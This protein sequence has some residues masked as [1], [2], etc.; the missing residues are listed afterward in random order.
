MKHLA[1]AAVLA[2]A[3]PASAQQETYSIDPAHTVPLFEVKHFGMSTQ[4]GFFNKASGKITVDRAAKTGNAD[5]AIDVGSVS[6]S[7]PKLADHLRS[8]DFFDAAKFPTATFK[9]SDFKFEGDKLVAV[10]GDLT[11]RGVTK[12]VTLKVDA[13]N[14]GAHPVNKKTMCGADVTTTIKRSDFGVKFGIP[15]VGDDVKLSIPVEAFK[16]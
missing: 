15:A 10:N 3:L 9:G 2:A 11:L 5:I 4:R 7:V 1:L 8:E 16:D 12:P 6:T 14:C 13:F